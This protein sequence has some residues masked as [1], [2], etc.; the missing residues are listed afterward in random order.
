[1]KIK[2]L[3]PILLLLSSCKSEFTQEGDMVDVENWAARKAVIAPEDSLEY[4]K[5]YLS[6]YSQIYSFS[7]HKKYNLTGMISL[8]NTS[9]QD[10]IYLL[11]TRYYD[12]RGTKIRT[13][14]EEPVFLRPMETAEIVIEQ[15]DTEGGTGSNFIIEWQKPAD[16]PEPLFEGVMNSMQGTQGIS[17][18]TQAK[19]IE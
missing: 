1:M 16:C 17:F 7:Q 14:F 18:T 19:R 10:T 12:T 9:D 11:S 4:G 15:D 5:S 2:Y 6:I 3:L 8:R 13:Y